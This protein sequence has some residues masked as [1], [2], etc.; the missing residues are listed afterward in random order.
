MAKSKKSGKKP[1]TNK[2][3]AKD[4]KLSEKKNPVEEKTVEK[5]EEKK[6]EKAPVEKTAKT[7][8]K[9]LNVETEEKKKVE[10]KK[11]CAVKGY[12]KAFFAKKY[13]GDESILTIFKDKKIYGAILGEF[14]GTMLIAMVIFTLGLYQ[15]LYLFFILLAIIV[16]T[17]RLSGANLNPINTLGMMAS[18]RVSAIRGVLYLLSQLIGAWVGTLIIT[19]FITAS[20][21]AGG[22]EVEL[23]GM[24]PIAEGNYWTVT[25]LEFLGATIVGFFFARAQD[26]KKNTLAYAAAVAGGFTIAV[27]VVYLLSYNYFGLTGSFMMNPAVALMYQIL[28]TSADGVG[29]LL[30]EIV[31]ALYTY[32][33]FPMVGG[34]LGFYLSDAAKTF[35]E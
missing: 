32:V 21:S 5:K 30:L 7:S 26:V 15:P 14:F 20:A 22:A 12:F 29:E 17:H 16:I 18:R 24:T 28:P 9:S 11:T 8:E 2:P 33:L 3:T 13:E 25:L 31:K 4:E 35:Q 19:A 1:K 10:K 27:V 34:V 23:P 6:A